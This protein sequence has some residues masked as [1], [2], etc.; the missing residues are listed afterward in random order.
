MPYTVPEIIDIAKVS[1][2]LA[3]METE[4]GMLFGQR[5]DPRLAQKIYM[6]RKSVE[7]A[8]DDDNDYEDI[9]ASANYLYALCGKYAILAN[10]VVN[11]ST[12]G[13]F[14]T[15][16]SLGQSP[17]L[18]VVRGSEFSNA[19]DYANLNLVGK[20]LSIFWNDI[21]RFLIPPGQDN[22][23]YEVTSTG[24]TILIDG[25]DASSFDY[26]FFIFITNSTSGTTTYNVTNTQIMSG[27]YVGT[28]GEEFFTA[29][30]LVGK[31]LLEVE[32]ESV[33]AIHIIGSGTPTVKQAL[34]DSTLGKITFSPDNPIAAG[35]N[36]TY[37]YQ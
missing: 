30:G 13:N 3:Q 33:N 2:Y 19:T 9:V 29:P 6:E 23:E 27:T 31:E 14:V 32:R 15:P 12:G 24:I 20:T 10:Y 5:K 18:I 35:E 7:W 37:L 26:T 17:Y 28:G 8:Y 11:S 36:I 16:V 1:G 34:F 25:F 4:K 21:P 22:P